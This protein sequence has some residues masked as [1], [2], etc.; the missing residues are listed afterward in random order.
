MTWRAIL[1]CS[2]VYGEEVIEDSMLCAGGNSRDACEVIYSNSLMSAGTLAINKTNLLQRDGGSPLTCTK[3]VQVRKSLK[4]EAIPC[5]CLLVIASWSPIPIFLTLHV[6][7]YRLFCAVW[8][9]SGS[10]ATVRYLAST[11]RSAIM[12]SGSGRI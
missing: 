2:A 5:M 10:D 8:H 4:Q 11:R 7:Y 6:N 3:G 1:D 9:R 12:W